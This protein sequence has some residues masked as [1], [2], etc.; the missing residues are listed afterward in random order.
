VPGR[1]GAPGSPGGAT[2]R[3][4]SSTAGHASDRGM[5]AQHNPTHPA[6]PANPALT[7]HQATHHPRQN[8]NR[9]RNIIERP[10]PP[11][12]RLTSPPVLRQH[13]REPRPRQRNRQRPRVHPIVSSPPEPPMKEHNHRRRRPRSP[14]REPEVSNLLRPI[15]VPQN[16]IRP[17]RRPTQYTVPVHD[18]PH[19]QP[20]LIHSVTCGGIRVNAG[21]PVSVS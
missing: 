17:R 8:L 15:A 19:P 7:S 12:T 16:T 14:S 10:R 11:A 2:D 6:N 1:D 13:N 20:S 9:P 5:P 18:P 4:A 3:K 21:A